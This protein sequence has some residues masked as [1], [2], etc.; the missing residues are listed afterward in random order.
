MAKRKAAAPKIDDLGEKIGGARKDAAQKLGPR[1]P[2][3]AD[4][5]TRPG[6]MRRFVPAQELA[7][8]RIFENGRMV[9][10]TKPLSTWSLLDTKKKG[11]SGHPAIKRGF[12]SEE[13]AK[14]AIPLAAV[15]QNHYVRG[16]GIGG[17][18]EIWRKTTKGSVKALDQTFPTR[19]AALAHMAQNAEALLGQKT[20]AGYGEEILAKPEKVFRQGPT[21]RS[22]DVQGEAFRK[23]FGF[24][25]VEFGLWNSD[26]ERQV[27]M[28][29][30]YDAMH[31]LGKLTGLNPT[32]LALNDKL[33]LAFGARGH[34][35]K[36]A[37]R[38]HYE[39][40]YGAINL[41]KMG[42]AG[43]LAHEWWHAVDHYLARVDN[44]KLSEMKENAHGHK[45]FT[46]E[47]RPEDYASHRVANAYAK[48]DLNPSVR[49]AYAELMD[50]ILK[51]EESYTEDIARTEKAAAHTRQQLDSHIKSIRQDLA[52]ERSYGR[53]VAGASADQL[54]RFDKLAKVIADG[55]DVK[56]D[57]KRVE[58][59]ANAGYGSHRWTNETLEKIGE[60]HKEVR[61]RSGF[62]N[63]KVNGPLD[64]LAHAMKAHATQS[65]NL[66]DAQASTLK[67]RKVATEFFREAR[68]LDQARTTPYW[69]TN[70]ELAARAFTAYI[71]DKA[72]AKGLKSDF[73]SYGSENAMYK[74]FGEASPFPEGA[75]RAKI[76]AAFDKLFG[77]IRKADLIKSGPQAEVYAAMKAAPMNEAPAA[78]TAAKHGFQ[79]ANNLAAAMKA[80]GKALPGEA[81]VLPK[82]EQLSFLPEPTTKDKVRAAASAKGKPNAAQKPM[83]E[84][85]FGSSKDQTDLVDRVKTQTA[86]PANE[87][88]WQRA[89]R[90]AQE[91]AARAKLERKLGIA[92]LIGAPV[93][94]AM[95]AWDASKNSAHAGNDKIANHN[96]MKAATVAGGTTLAIGAA[97][98]AGFHFGLKGLAS[99][100]PKIGRF[101]ARSS[102]WALAA[103]TAYG[104]WQ[105]YKNTGTVAGAATGAFSGGEVME[106]MKRQ[107]AGPQRLTP[108]QQQQFDVANAAHHA[109]HDDIASGEVR[110]FERDRRVSSGVVVHET[111]K[112]HVRKKAA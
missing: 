97:G 21:Y 61:G 57:W 1:A 47:G 111:V 3:P 52:T 112:A 23:T 39:R 16:V 103:F 76:N 92:T 102:P 15:S 72:K 54:A 17:E 79:N 12:P 53:K 51:K 101:A 18:A 43:T 35:G 40:D 86:A 83:D 104:A 94:A 109:M 60:L 22:G 108:S 2:K 29:H 96:A 100:A 27:V 33:G 46:T 10:K 74:A 36:G 28:N 20:R 85:L 64:S 81:V 68:K 69:T 91:Q 99:V 106:S 87:K 66:A 45:V 65:A 59:K 78:Q 44:P 89:M 88:P 9:V 105:G 30:A 62:G 58:G 98:T 11:Y 42:G 75:E 38:A 80:Q 34:G 32:G 37:A 48:G 13:A 67:T 26:L 84:G 77:E 63:A 41:T 55:K 107:P 31:D 82:A 49:S 95:I 70:H 25:G 73:L 71:E 7:Q 110:S 6:W 19:E 14:R 4:T 56:V 8:E 5:D 93:A 24:R 90:L 50:S